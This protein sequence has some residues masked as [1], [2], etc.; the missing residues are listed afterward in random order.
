[1]ENSNRE[2]QAPTI[3]TPEEFYGLDIEPTK[4]R[5]TRSYIADDIFSLHHPSEDEDSGF[6]KS[7]KREIYEN[8]DSLSNFVYLPSVDKYVRYPNKDMHLMLRTYRNRNLLTVD[9]QNTLYDKTIM[10]AGLSVGSNILENSVQ[11]AIGDS[12]IIADP[13]IITPTNLNRIRASMAD[14]GMRKTTWLGDKISMMDPYIRQVHLDEGYSSLND[15]CI[16]ELRPDCIVEEVDDIKSKAELRKLAKSL[17]IPLVMGGDIDDTVVLDIERHD[18]ED[19][20][21]FNGK[22]SKGQF[23]DILNGEQLSRRNTESILLKLNGGLRTISPR[24]IDS[25]IMRGVEL[26]GFPQLATTATAVGAL[27]S[28]A[29]R[30]ILLGRDISSGT[31]V[32]PL[33]KSIKSGSPDSFSDNI[34]TVRRFIEY[35][36]I[37]KS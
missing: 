28:L 34:K 25:S 30:E 1:M 23:D 13:D 27:A 18:I 24:L 10:G 15:S 8:I 17:S 20:K 21:P 35:R 2:W 7:K 16:Q 9:E 19:V 14:V 32:L 3:L 12:Y 31:Y 5:D 6:A 29:V 22:I 37:N 4:V 11:S 33:R 26:S 36:K